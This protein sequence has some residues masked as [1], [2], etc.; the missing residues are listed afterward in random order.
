MRA[1][2]PDEWLCVLGRPEVGECVGAFVSWIAVVSFD[3]PPV[4][5]V[6]SSGVIECAPEVDVLDCLLVGGLPASPLPVVDPLGYASAYV[7]AVG[8]QLDLARSLERSEC[9]DDR[10][11]LHPVVRG[12]R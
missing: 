3:P 8:E 4:D 9:L 2:M 5:A 7:L 12:R 1:G 11:Q 6:A 10:C